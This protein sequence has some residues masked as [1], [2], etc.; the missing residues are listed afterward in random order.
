M[1]KSTNNFNVRLGVGYRSSLAATE[2]G[3]IIVAIDVLRCSSSIVT[4]L[5]NGARAVI[6]ARSL[7]EARSLSK[8]HDAILAGERRGMRP[9]GFELGNSPLEFGK[10]RVQNRTIVMT[11]TSGTKAIVLG[12][13]A[14]RLLVG[15]FLNL[16]ATVKFGVRMA[17]SLG[18][19]ISLIAA[20]TRGKFSLEDFLCAGALSDLFKRDGGILDDGCVASAYAYRWA[21]SDLYSAVREGLHAKYLESI[22]LGD[23]VTFSTKIDLFRIAAALKANCIVAVKP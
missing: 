15:S 2:R 14:R 17:K 16:S 11:T 21:R 3:D 10:E 1:M 8:A 13:K 7:R 18:S 6:P 22:D 4:A 5:A 20:G 12:R 9:R 23:D 19:G